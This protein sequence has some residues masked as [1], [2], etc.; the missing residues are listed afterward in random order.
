MTTAQIE[1]TKRYMPDFLK[2]CDIL[3]QKMQTISLKDIK[4]CGI[5]EGTAIEMLIRFAM[6]SDKQIL[7]NIKTVR[8]HYGR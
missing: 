4:S 3:E 6:L 2:L 8:S 1:N 5:A 7:R